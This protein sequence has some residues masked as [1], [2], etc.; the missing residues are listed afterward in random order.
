MHH[1]APG[2][3]HPA[4]A[5]RFPRVAV[6]LVTFGLLVATCG[7]AHSS[8]AARSGT[9]SPLTSSPTP[10]AAAYF[11]LKLPGEIPELFAP[12]IINIPDRSVGRIAFSP[13]ARECAFTVFE[14]I[15]AHNRILFTRHENGAWTAQ[16]P[17]AGVEGRETL[18]P[19]F[20]RDDSRLY[21]AV[22][23][24]GDSPNVDFWEAQRSGAGWSKP[25]PL[26]A[27]LNSTQNEFCL[28]Q[29]A[30]GTMYFASR[31]EGGH[32]GL[33]LY[34]TVAGPGQPLQVENLGTAVNSASDDGDPALSPDGRV[35]VFY[36]SS[37][38]PRPTGNSDLF[39]CFNNGQGGW[40]TPV[41]LG[42]GFNTPAQEYGATF[43]HDGR[44]LFFVRFDGEKGEVY[45]VST[46][47]LER[48]RQRSEAAGALPE[49]P[50]L[51]LPERKSIHVSPEILQRY[52]GTYA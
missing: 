2:L 14:S 33:D 5:S 37:N 48:F 44:A 20:A 50:A 18:E 15:Y 52:V 17:W 24:P 42:E 3:C 1:P 32:G 26:S 6:A 40:T 16:T 39:I 11:G 12:G 47:A 34:R 21:F 31:R 23:S 22:K 29:T 36:S 19:L 49:S 13:D 28:T 9:A 8:E 41:N 35:L 45:W 27:P 10:A 43:S 51:L 4:D 30:D 38:R 7:S 46:A 25:Q